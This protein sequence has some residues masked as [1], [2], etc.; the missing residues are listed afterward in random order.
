MITRYDIEFENNNNVLIVNLDFYYEFSNF[1]Y[2]EYTKN[3]KKEIEKI[4]KKNGARKV[5]IV[6]GSVILSTLIL[7]PNYTI[8]GANNTFITNNTIKETIKELPTYED[9]II[10]DVS[11]EKE[12]VNNNIENNIPE[13][14]N[15]NVINTPIKNSINNTTKP[16]ENVNNKLNNKVSN[17]FV[18]NGTNNL[19]D[20]KEDTSEK[21]ENNTLAPKHEEP[22]KEIIDNKTYITLYRSNGSINELE[23]NEYLIGVIASEMPASFNIEALKAQAI[24]ART[25]ALKRISENKKLTDTVSTQSYKDNNELKIIWGNNFN[26]YYTKIK[27]AV[28]STED[29]VLM[30]NN[31]YIDAVYHST[32]NGKTEDAINVWGNDIPYLKS[33]DSNTDINASS[34]KRDVSFSYEK[35]SNI[36]NTPITKYSDFILE[37]NSSGRINNVKINNIDI[38]GTTFRSLLS[39]RSTDFTIELTDEKIIITTFGY[40]HGVGMSQYGANGLANLGY[41]YEKILKH[42]YQG[43]TLKKI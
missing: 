27:E 29:I 32:S 21:I 39:L 17:S 30:Y 42:Y 6:I 31:N 25:Y 10:I 8:E 43:V 37:R 26:K 34:Y 1:D 2:K 36:L 12:E 15:N 5:K 16:K 3:L 13:K 11:T 38:K 40:G 41:S 18:N 19:T 24:V 35:L 14:E 22:L 4:A 23:I 33:V 9:I 28:M 20:K 7:T